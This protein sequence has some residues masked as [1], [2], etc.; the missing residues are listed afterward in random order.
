MHDFIL[1]L[2]LGPLYVAAT[3]QSTMQPD[4][5]VSRA[6]PIMLKILP[7]M[8]LSSGQKILHLCYAYNYCNYT[9]VHT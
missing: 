4:S 3:Y 6:R 1:A 2:V 5:P 7:F 8:L 9:T